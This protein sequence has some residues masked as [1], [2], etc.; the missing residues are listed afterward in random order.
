MIYSLK[1]NSA[2]VGQWLFD[3]P[4][5]IA[6]QYCDLGL[7]SDVNM[8]DGHVI[9]KFGFLQALHFPSTWSPNK[10]KHLCQLE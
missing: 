1:D 5:M 2:L 6:S 3:W 7:I 4:G 10:R 9:N 8:W